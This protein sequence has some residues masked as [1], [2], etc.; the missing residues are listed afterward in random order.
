MKRTSA[1]LWYYL[2]LIIFS[3]VIWMPSR[4]YPLFW[5]SASVVGIANQISAGNFVG[6][7]LF[8][9]VLA[10]LWKVF[11]TEAVIGHYLTLPAL[12]I[13][14]ISSYEIIKAKT[15]R[16]LAFLSAALIGLTPVVLAEYVNVFTTLPMAALSA[17][18]LLLWL[19]K[20]YG[21][22]LIVYLAAILIDFPAIIISIY[23]LTEALESTDKK[24]IRYGF[25]G[26]VAGLFAWFI[27]ARNPLIQLLPNGLSTALSDWP[28]MVLTLG[29]AQGRWPITILG[30]VSA[31][32]LFLQLGKTSFLC[33]IAHLKKEGLTLLAATVYFALSGE[34]NFRNTIFILVFFY[35]AVVF[36]IHQLLQLKPQWTKIITAILLASGL[37]ITSFWRPIQAPYTSSVFNPPDDLGITDY[38]QVF[39]WLSAYTTLT[40]TKNVVYY[41]GFPE[42][43]N[44]TEPKMGFVNS[45][46][47]IQNCADYVYDSSQTQIIILH[48]FSPTL[49]PCFQIIQTNKLQAI[50]GTEINGKWLDL[51]VATVS[52]E[53]LN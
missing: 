8:P 21:F 9:A 31:L 28:K 37:Y 24:A 36:V 11:G 40:A 42:S 20:K 25:S 5:D 19:R 13:L 44:L 12:P 38:L 34:F 32:I 23:F 53:K 26:L 2:T 16:Q 49:Y 22:W 45:P 33:L 6:T 41:G 39:R 10:L 27:I 52:A 7:S 29:S 4:F 48:P 14:L 3:V 51:Y 46:I 43:I 1:D 17:L 30:I 47:P 15:N 50:A 35:L 18:S